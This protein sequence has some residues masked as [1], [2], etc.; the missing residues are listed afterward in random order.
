MLREKPFDKTVE[1]EQIESIFK[2]L[3]K[4]IIRRCSLNVE[5]FERDGN[6]IDERLN[7]SCALDY[8]L[9]TNYYKKSKMYKS[10]SFIYS[11]REVDEDISKS[12]IKR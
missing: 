3:V 7:N 9:Q 5:L 12:S 11:I 4:P 1:E 8:T 10:N 2:T 6:T